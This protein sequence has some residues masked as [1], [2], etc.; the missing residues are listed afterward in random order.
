MKLNI[1]CHKRYLNGWINADIRKVKPLDIVLDARY[2]LPFKN[3]SL[4]FIYSEHFIEHLT[5]EEGEFFFK[6]CHRTLKPSGIVRTATICLDGM[7][8]KYNNS[9][10]DQN[11]LKNYP[12][13]KTS[14]QMLNACFYK[15]HHKH[16]YNI[17]DLLKIQTVFHSK[18]RY[19]IGDSDTSFLKDL[20][21]RAESL[22]ITEAQ[23]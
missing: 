5:Y 17:L 6:E 4:D 1:G 19:S 21:H 10:D 15:W 23:K 22:L 18:H 7:I 13:I 2:N 11:W 20:E 16:V 8:Q 14:G 3:N 12:E 9:W